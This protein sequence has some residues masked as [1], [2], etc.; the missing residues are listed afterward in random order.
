MRRTITTFFAMLVMAA[1]VAAPIVSSPALAQLQVPD[2]GE[3]VTRVPGQLTDALED[4]VEQTRSQSTRGAQ[5][6]LRAKNKKVSRLLRRNSK[7]IERDAN[8]DLAKRGELIAIDLH[9]A[10]RTALK[11]AGFGVGE[12]EQIEE[13]G[14]LVITL[15]APAGMDLSA[16]QALASTLAPNAE[17]SANV[18]HFPSGEF[19]GGE[20]TVSPAF[21]AAS[22]AARIGLEVGVID[23]APGASVR[24]EGE[25]GFAKGA[26]APANHGS[27]VV[28]LLHRAGVKRIRVADVYGLD[29]AG[30]NALA[31]TRALGW[32][33]RK[34]SRIITISLVGPRSTLLQ[35]AISAARNRGI[36]VVAA[37]GNDG[38]ASP[39][40]F[41]ASYKGV[42][43]V[44]G[45]DR[46]G[47][48]LIE[49][50]RALHLDYA[51]PGDRVYAHNKRG[52]LRRWRGTSF[53]T[54]LVAARIAF[55]LERSRNWRKVTDAEA[56]DLGARGPD[57]IYGRGLLCENCGK[58]K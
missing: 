10:E 19:G 50:G 55:A 2:A 26:P 9:A 3:P 14:L 41:P 34:G 37:V 29:P 18:L 4:T 39:P 33:T 57:R 42:I 54:P 12:I 47:R 48:V 53:A 8:G 13:L 20:T 27:A 23:T 21:M 44:T 40:A 6:L 43:A 38:P 45:V 31:I 52:K 15:T 30:G 1:L 24:V 17:I 5:R 56:R 49:A 36:V 51:A 32:L 35:R 16:A 46:R 28:S 11:S 7:F 22:S 58:R 25:R